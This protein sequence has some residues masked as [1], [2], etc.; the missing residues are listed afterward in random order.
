VCFPLKEGITNVSD[1][2]GL[3]QIDAF[4]LRGIVIGAAVLEIGAMIA[5][6]LIDG[7]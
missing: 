6:L 2:N 4:V 7:R 5:M 1:K 3:N